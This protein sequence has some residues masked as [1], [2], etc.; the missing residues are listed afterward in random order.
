MANELAVFS[1]TTTNASRIVVWLPE[2]RF[3]IVS[4]SPG[5]KIRACVVI[6]TRVLRTVHV[7]KCASGVSTGFQRMLSH[8]VDVVRLGSSWSLEQPC[9]TI[10]PQGHV[11]LV[12][13]VIVRTNM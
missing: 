12:P 2:E 1:T 3:S 8:V 13:H 10:P 7:V 6:R 4:P 5:I 9:L 11:H